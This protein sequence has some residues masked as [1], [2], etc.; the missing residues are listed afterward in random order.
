M[1][2]APFRVM[3]GLAV[4]VIHHRLALRLAHAEADSES[5]YP[6]GAPLQRLL[7]NSC[8][9]PT[10]GQSFPHTTW[11]TR[12]IRHCFPIQYPFCVA[13]LLSVPPFDAGNEFRNRLFSGAF[14][15][16]LRIRLYRLLKMER[17]SR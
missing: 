16:C 8:P 15:S 17:N 9:A 13:Y 14:E 12:H 3:L 6:G 2:E 4:D 5:V 1:L 11:I 7:R 10:R